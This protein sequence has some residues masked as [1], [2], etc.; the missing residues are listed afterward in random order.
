MRC[1]PKLDKE[2]PVC[3]TTRVWTEAGTSTVE[4][5]PTRVLEN[6][7]SEPWCSHDTEQPLD[8]SASSL[9]L[10]TGVP[11]STSPV[12]CLVTVRIGDGGGDGVSVPGD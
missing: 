9:I 1:N 4:R 11:V 7:V 8:P 3:K 12:S 10:K 5:V 2:Q 6:E